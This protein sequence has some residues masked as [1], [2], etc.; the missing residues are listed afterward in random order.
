MTGELN[1]RTKEAKVNPVCCHFPP[2]FHPF[3]FISLSALNF[4][5]VQHELLKTSLIYD[6]LP[7]KPMTEPPSNSP[8]V[9]SLP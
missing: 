4:G 9:R 7:N 5:H 8:S 2:S 6:P 3:H 1:E